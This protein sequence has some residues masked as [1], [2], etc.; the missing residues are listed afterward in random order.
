[1]NDMNFMDYVMSTFFIVL[2]LMFI[3]ATIIL[4]DEH[5]EN[6]ETHKKLSNHYSVMGLSENK[7]VNSMIKTSGESSSKRIKIIKEINEMCGV[8]NVK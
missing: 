5:N 3:T 8:K 7:C 2:I 1:M 6:G 4:I